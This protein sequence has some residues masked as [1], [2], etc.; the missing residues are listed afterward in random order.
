MV[1][2]QDVWIV[3]NWEAIQWMR[4]P[5][6]Q[7]QMKEFTEWKTCDTPLPIE[8]QACNIPNV[9]KLKSRELRKERYLY[10]CKEC[11]DTYPWIKNEFGTD[12]K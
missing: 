6:P 11:P 10:T 4:N 9:C 5:T 3:S 12:F 8:E 2:R 7:A 1:S